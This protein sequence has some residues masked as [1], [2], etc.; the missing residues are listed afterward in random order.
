MRLVEALERAPDLNR[1]QTPTRVIKARQWGVGSLDPDEL[2]PLLH[3]VLVLVTHG[4]TDPE[5]ARRIYYSPE[6]VKDQVKAL[7][8]VF[9]A[10]NR[11]H[12]AALAVAQGFVDMTLAA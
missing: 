6:S 5:I 7:C 10:R 1:Y 4:H 3:R 12:L 11:T 9:S 8:A 2:T